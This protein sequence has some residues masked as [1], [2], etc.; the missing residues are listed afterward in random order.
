MIFPATLSADYPV[1]PGLGLGSARAVTGLLEALAIGFVSAVFLWRCRVC[2]FGMMWMLIMYLPSANIIPLIQYF[3]AERYLYGP[4][5]GLCLLAG[6]AID[7]LL[8]MRSVARDPQVRRLVL[9]AALAVAVLGAARS[10]ARTH[11]WR[12]E[13]A[14]WK[15]SLSAGIETYRVRYNV[16]V[17]LFRQGRMVEAAKHLKRAVALAPRDYRSRRWLAASLLA[18]GRLE[19]AE[20]VCA[21]VAAIAQEDPICAFVGAE[22]S[23]SKGDM[24]KAMTGYHRALTQEGDHLGALFRLSRLL[25]SPEWGSAASADSAVLFAERALDITKS[26]GAVYRAE[27]WR[28][29]VGG[30]RRAGR[31]RK[32]RVACWSALAE[33]PGD[34]ELLELRRELLE[35]PRRGP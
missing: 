20:A 33:F 34:S 5:F 18:M 35:P 25:S 2:M 11:D 27:A 7:R 28:C 19:E 29:L 22:L 13:L 26:H 6:V 3:G 16:G 4:S 17:E 31:L 1:F 14:L 30:L 9:G 24:R 21:D 10:A 12:D 23:F 15:S 32:A 8:A